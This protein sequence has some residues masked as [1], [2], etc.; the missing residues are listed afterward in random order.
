[1]HYSLSPCVLLKA[2]CVYV[3]RIQPQCPPKAYR[4]KYVTHP[5]RLVLFFCMHTYVMSDA[6]VVMMGLNVMMVQSIFI[7]LDFFLSVHFLPSFL[8]LTHLHH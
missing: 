2:H 5:V 7:S 4:H 1:M 8:C 6:I 3:L